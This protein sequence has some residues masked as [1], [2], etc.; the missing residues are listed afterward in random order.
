M[1]TDKQEQ[2]EAFLDECSHEE[3]LTLI[4]RITQRLRQLEE[5]KPQSLYGIWKG[6][7]PEDTDIDGA[8]R[9]IRNR[10]SKDFEEIGKGE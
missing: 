2:I 9:E 3:L 7:F 10:W 4:E 5:R 6:K 1:V 8:L